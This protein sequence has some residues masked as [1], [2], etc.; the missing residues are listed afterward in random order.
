MHRAAADLH[1]SPPLATSPLP[2][3]Q[4]GTSSMSVSV[5]PYV[6]RPTRSVREVLEQRLAQ[7]RADEREIES[8]YDTHT[9]GSLEMLRRIADEKRA[10]SEELQRL[11]EGRA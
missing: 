5:S 10:T 11:D 2:V 3:L 7:L 1:R 9:P 6:E 4:N 8:A